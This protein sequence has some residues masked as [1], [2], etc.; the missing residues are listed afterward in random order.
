MKAIVFGGSGFLGSH[1]AETLTEKGY[2][3]SIYDIKPSKYLIEGKQE[4]IVGDILDADSIMAA[5]K[6]CD[7]V[8]DFA[9]LADLDSASTR[10]V[11]TVM[12]NVVGTCNI[13]D[14]CVSHKVKRF[15]YASSFYANSDKGGFY[16]CSKQAAEI[17]IEEYSRKY[18]L[19][20]TILRYGSLYGPR[21]DSNNGIRKMLGQALE[22][23][24]VQYQGSGE[25]TREYIH[26]KDAARLSVQI[27][28]E[29]YRNKHI[30]LTGHDA[31]KVKDIIRVMSEILNKE[32]KVEYSNISSELHYDV[33][34]YTYK[35]RSNYKLVND[36]YHDLG[37]GLIECLEEIDESGA[38]QNA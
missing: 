38:W 17:Y 27:L 13:M 1:V 29:D 35:P 7:A 4:M 11:D 19:D 28:E 32:L 8:Y 9:G 10:P 6:G 36:F 2:E 23:G 31:Y 15:V 14:A 24:T 5:V 12:L 22:T 34:P 37:Q 25:E 30:V 3:V 16:R 26:V 33:T 18:G 21:S 20:Y